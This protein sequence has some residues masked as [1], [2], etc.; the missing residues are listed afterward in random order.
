MF[1]V[2]EQTYVIV[3]SK[4]I[5]SQLHSIITTSI[6]SVITIIYTAV[7]PA[8]ASLKYDCYV[9]IPRKQMPHCLMSARSLFYPETQVLD[10]SLNTLLYRTLKDRS[11]VLS[12]VGSW[13]TC[14][15]RFK[16]EA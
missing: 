5:G 14:R 12:A 9:C 10:S 6:G 1:G 11:W 16:A 7:I 13:K 8:A 15:C 3:V 2:A 4:F